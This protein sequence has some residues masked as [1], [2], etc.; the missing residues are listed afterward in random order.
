MTDGLSSTTEDAL[1]ELRYELGQADWSDA[2][3]ARGRARGLRGRLRG[4]AVP[5]LLVVA[6]WLLS[7]N[8]LMAGFALLGCVSGLALRTG[9]L[10]GRHT[11]M[12][13]ALGPWSATVS[14]SGEAVRFG[15][16]DMETRR[17]WRSLGG[18]VES[19]AGFVLL[20]PAPSLL[21]VHY[22]PKRSLDKAST[23]RLRGILDRRLPRRGGRPPR[24]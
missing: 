16:A 17:G 22:L 11:R 9:V 13:A 2:I 7:G 14:D 19:D 1:V 8:A 12:N 21:V 18:Y 3:R 20:A 15:C 4:L 24:H 10:A 6:V 5:V 23:D